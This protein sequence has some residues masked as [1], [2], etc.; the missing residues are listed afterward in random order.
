[1]EMGQIRVRNLDD[2]VVQELKDRAA[3]LGTSVESMLRSLII[4]E[5]ARPRRDMLAELRRHQ[6]LMRESH[7]LQPDSTSLIRDERGR[8]S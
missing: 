2:G 1:M 4:E 8:W 6:E 3:H 7:G 5:A